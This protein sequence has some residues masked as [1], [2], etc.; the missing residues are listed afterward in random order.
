M[1]RPLG[2]MIYNACLLNNLFAFGKVCPK[3][4]TNN[5]YL[6]LFNI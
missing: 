5:C 4:A 1:N 3:T 6:V 2:M